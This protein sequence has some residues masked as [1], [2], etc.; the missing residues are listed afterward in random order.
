MCINRHVLLVARQ[1]GFG[2]LEEVCRD[3]NLLITQAYNFCDMVDKLATY[4]YSIIFIDNSSFPASDDVLDLLK[5]KNYYVPF[6]VVLNRTPLPF[7]ALN[8][9]CVNPENYLDLDKAVDYCKANDK[10]QSFLYSESFLQETIS[11]N[12]IKLGFSR[13]Y[14]GF[15]FLSS[16]IYRLFTNENSINSLRNSVYPFVASLYGVTE[17]SIERDVRNLLKNTY[18]MATDDSV[19]KEKLG[20]NKPTCKNI[21]I[22]VSSEVR[23]LIGC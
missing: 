6:V 14:K 4:R 8:V 17:T 9:L 23:T 16:I 20:N 19:L 13:K 11:D 22:I 10:S 12:L 7:N 18:R 15:A 21:I 2:N 3:K 1:N 5:L